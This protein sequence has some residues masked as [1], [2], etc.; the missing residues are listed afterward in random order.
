MNT[1]QTGSEFHLNHEEIMQ[2]VNAIPPLPPSV[3]QLNKLFA[4]PYYDF[5]D[6]VRAVELDASLSGK[7]LHLANCASRG[8][9][10]ADSIREADQQVTLR[11]READTATSALAAI[12]VILEDDDPTPPAEP[13]SK[14]GSG[15]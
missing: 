5:K 2:T 7:L 1:A 14:E 6:V 11:V 4:D 9:G 12:N 10:R 13:E 3:E 8:T 15:R